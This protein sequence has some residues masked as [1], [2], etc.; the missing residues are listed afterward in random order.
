MSSFT[1]ADI[2]A[3]WK[4]CGHLCEHVCNA[5]FRFTKYPAARPSVVPQRDLIY[6]YK[7]S[8]WR[9]GIL[10]PKL[11]FAGFSECTFNGQQHICLWLSPDDTGPVKSLRMLMRQCNAHFNHR[12]VLLLI[13]ESGQRLHFDTKAVG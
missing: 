9:K 3:A 11:M 1:F 8:L 13:S 12:E 4:F 5:A 10:S 2:S 6:V 7:C